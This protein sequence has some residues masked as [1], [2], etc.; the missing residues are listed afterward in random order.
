[1]Q[2]PLILATRR[3]RRDASRLELLDGF[4]EVLPLLDLRRIDTSLLAQL[5]VIPKDH[6]CEIVRHSIGFSVND[7][8]LRRRRI[9]GLVKPSLGNLVG[10]VF[11][12]SRGDLFIIP[13]RP[14]YGTR[15]G[16]PWT[17][18]ASATWP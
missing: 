12:N 7:E 17:E 2:G 11:A 18:A 10:N 14:N 8:I 1:M 4:D 5:F 9:K 16:D 6:R 15:S 13:H 3:Y